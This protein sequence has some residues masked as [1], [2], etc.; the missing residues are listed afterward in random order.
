MVWTQRKLKIAANS[1]LPPASIVVLFFTFRLA[2]GNTQTVV[3]QWKNRRMKN[4]C[5]GF[6]M[7]IL[8][9][10]T[11]AHVQPLWFDDLHYSNKK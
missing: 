4:L 6:I 8:P 1:V 11:I 5:L 9:L 2:G 10:S 3:Q 7:S